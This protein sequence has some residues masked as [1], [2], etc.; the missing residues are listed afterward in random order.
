M[1]KEKMNINR[2]T[3]FLVACLHSMKVS[4]EVCTIVIACCQTEKQIGTMMDWIKKHHQENPSEDEI[5]QIAELIR[6]KVK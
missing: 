2:M 5:L 4:K 1:K 3:E 6:E